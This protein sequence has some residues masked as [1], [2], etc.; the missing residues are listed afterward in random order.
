MSVN[1]GD[2]WTFQKQ[3]QPYFQSADGNNQNKGVGQDNDINPMDLIKLNDIL[4]SS[5]K[6][7]DDEAIKDVLEAK[8]TDKN[9]SWDDTTAI[10]EMLDNA[11]E[12][13][14][15]EYSQDKKTTKDTPKKS[16]DTKTTKP[17]D[18]E[19]N[20]AGSTT[21]EVDNKP[22]GSKIQITN[23]TDTYTGED[24]KDKDAKDAKKDPD[25]A[26]KVKS[27]KEQLK[28]QGINIKAGNKNIVIDEN[29][30]VSV[31]ID[32]WEPNN[33]EKSIDTPSRLMKEV[34]N[35]DWNEGD[36]KDIYNQLMKANSK[37]EMTD[38]QKEKYGFDYM[39][40]AND[41]LA[42]YSIDELRAGINGEK[43]ELTQASIEK[44]PKKNDTVETTSGETTTDE[45][46][47]EEVTS[48]KEAQT[49]QKTTDTTETTSETTGQTQELSED[50]QNKLSDLNMFGIEMD[51]VEI[52]NSDSES[53][54]LKTSYDNQNVE[55]TIDNKN[56]AMNF[57]DSNTIIE[58][59]QDSKNESGVFTK[60][61][62]KNSEKNTITTYEGRT[63]KGYETK[64]KQYLDTG[65]VDVQSELNE[66]GKY[67]K[68]IS[69]N[70]NGYTE[71]YK[72]YGIEKNEYNSCDRINSDGTGFVFKSDENGQWAQTEI[73]TPVQDTLTAAEG[74]HCYP[75]YTN[76]DSEEFYFVNNDGF[77]KLEKKV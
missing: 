57:T 71:I 68:K 72:D 4:S 8:Y 50:V 62:I 52:T 54:T 63:E 25:N 61:I 69:T 6:T 55:I 41:T 39:L 45:T 24:T 42:L 27:K 13:V 32:K 47:D 12:E 10:F 59:P 53:V 3:N 36:T 65:V 29:N 17:D 77:K 19:T 40:L 64:T 38:S 49:E 33:D 74:G 75:K 30:K 66:Y 43:T 67:D 44:A 26:P 22:V 16:E 37:A 9:F 48:D 11:Q 5:G 28:E 46:S 14:V 21:T 35:L 58:F 15:Q 34:Y 70:P 23:V 56:F 2:R 73:M 20:E 31:N 76:Q 60:K 1:N 51:N 7:Y 18:N